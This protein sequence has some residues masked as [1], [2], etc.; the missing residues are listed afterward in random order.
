MSGLV[1]ETGMNL[2]AAAGPIWVTVAYIGLYYLFLLH[3]LRVKIRLHREYQERGE[4][5]DRYFSQDREMLAAD[6][7]Q[8]NML[9]QMPAFLCALWLHAL[10]VSP[11]TATLAG[12]AYTAMRAIYPLLLAGK[13]GREVPFRLFVVT[14]PSYA[15]IGY[16]LITVVLQL[17]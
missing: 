1:A 10:F 5:F 16:L 17:L 4:T 11:V 8:L 14:M 2:D 12:A 3:I 13:M 6:R 7:T 9:E 15:V